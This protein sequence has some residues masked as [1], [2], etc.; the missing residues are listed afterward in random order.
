MENYLL[1]LPTETCLQCSYDHSEVMDKYLHTEISQYG[2]VGPFPMDSLPGSHISRFGVILKGHQT[3]KWRLIVDLS[4]PHGFSVN[5]GIPKFL[6]S[7]KFISIDDAIN[8][9]LKLGPGTLLPNI[10][11]KNAFKLIPVLPADKHL[12]M[13]EWKGSLFVDMCL[14]FGLILDQLQGCS[15]FWLI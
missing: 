2:V 3:N 4:H 5:D 12:L 6:C 10:D 14:L 15:T 13:I 11:I 7:M 9:I 1:N 8:K